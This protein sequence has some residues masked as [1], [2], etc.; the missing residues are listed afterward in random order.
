M[1]NTIHQLI[2]AMATL[3]PESQFTIM[4]EQIAIAK[5]HGYIDYETSDSLHSSISSIRENHRESMRQMTKLLI[6]LQDECDT[7]L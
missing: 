3:G 1:V 4:H 7:T 5:S 2:N 6:K